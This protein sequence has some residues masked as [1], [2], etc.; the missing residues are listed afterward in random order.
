MDTILAFFDDSL[1]FVDPHFAGV[2]EFL[3][4]SWGEAAI[5]N[6]ENDGIKEALVAR[7]KRTVYKNVASVLQV[8]GRHRLGHFAFSDDA[9]DGFFDGDTFQLSPLNRCLNGSRLCVHN[10]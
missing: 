5:E 7:I 2:S 3:R 6:S 9:F 8:S 10:F 1:D 4:A